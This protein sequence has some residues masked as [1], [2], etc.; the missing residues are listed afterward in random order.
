M[1]R[2]KSKNK[3]FYKLNEHEL[4]EIKLFSNYFS[5]M[6]IFVRGFNDFLVLFPISCNSQWQCIVVEWHNNWF[7]RLFNMRCTVRLR[8]CNVTKK[9]NSFPFIHS[10]FQHFYHFRLQETKAWKRLTSN[11]NSIV[12]TLPARAMEVVQDV[13]ERV[14]VSKWMRP[15]NFTVFF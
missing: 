6:H 7:M 11:P 8:E 1:A 9:E 2:I 13:V 15:P 12:R 4:N 14:R 10:I 5:S 3:P